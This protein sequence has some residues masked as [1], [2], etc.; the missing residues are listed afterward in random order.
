[1]SELG[2]IYG[3]ALEVP[4]GPENKL[5]LTRAAGLPVG[6]VH[7]F[8][9][10]LEL[11]PF[12]S[13]I[14]PPKSVSISVRTPASSID[15]HVRTWVSEPPDFRIVNLTTGE[16]TAFHASD[17]TVAC[18]VSPGIWNLLQIEKS[19]PGYEP[20]D[21]WKLTLN[22][23]PNNVEGLA[24]LHSSESSIFFL[25]VAG[26]WTAFKLLDWQFPEEMEALDHRLL[27]LDLPAN[28][29]DRLLISLDA[30]GSINGTLIYSNNPGSS[31]AVR[32]LEAGQALTN[33]LAKGWTITR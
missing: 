32:S 12:P 22:G 33:L 11:P 1:M 10:G 19:E 30:G 3:D 13:Y 28:L 27:A 2:Q 17:S 7:L 21:L 15:V 14:V 29:I 24:V 26:G 9:S 18:P 20:D 4:A 5:D 25:S 16:A 31:D 6:P 23:Y 8:G